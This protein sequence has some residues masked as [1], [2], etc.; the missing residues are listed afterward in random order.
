[1]NPLI[2]QLSKTVGTLRAC[3]VVELGGISG[4]VSA[5]HLETI[6]SLT[7]VEPSTDIISKIIEEYSP[8]SPPFEIRQSA[9][10]ELAFI[11]IDSVD[12]CISTYGSITSN[13]SERF[14]RQV[15]RILKDSGTFCFAVPHPLIATRALELLPRDY[16]YFDTQIIESKALKLGFDAPARLITKPLTRT[17]YEVRRAGMAIENIEEIVTSVDPTRSN[18]PDF[19]L[20]KARKI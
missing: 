10:I 5:R 20:I 19:T 6:D 1:M 12:T 2:A 14:F 16:R 11:N 9:L 8:E 15:K 17:F 13:D 4:L 18:V 3:R 7:V